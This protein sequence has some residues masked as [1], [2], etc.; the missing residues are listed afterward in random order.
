[1]EITEK[2]MV[3]TQKNLEEL[4][5]R[6]QLMDVLRDQFSPLTDDD[7]KLDVIVQIYLHKQADVPTM[8][9]LFSPKWGEPKDVAKS[10]KISQK[11]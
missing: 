4:F 5:S 7:F 1:M 8:V 9:G 10:I 6:N 2:N 11:R 3:E